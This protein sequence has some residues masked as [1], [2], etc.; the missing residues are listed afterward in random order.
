M[1]QPASWYRE[2]NAEPNIYL[3]FQWDT[4]LPRTEDVYSF[5]FIPITLDPVSSGI[6]SPRLLSITNMTVGLGMREPN[7]QI[8]DIEII[9]SDHDKSRNVRFPS[10][11]TE[12]FTAPDHTFS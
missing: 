4:S 12:L 2:K 5:G 8:A 7:T 6:L 10:F 11:P 3:L 9:L 1:V